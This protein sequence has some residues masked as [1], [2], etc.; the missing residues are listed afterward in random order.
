MKDKTQKNIRVCS[1]IAFVLCVLWTIFKMFYFVGLLTGKGGVAEKVNWSENNTIKIVYFILY[2]SS[3][4]MMIVLCFK[5]IINV[6]KGLREQIVFPQNNVKPLF[7]LALDSFVY[8]L[9][10]INQPLL[11][12]GGFAI[13]FVGTNFILPFLLLFF[14]FMYKVAADA[15]EENSLTI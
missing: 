14:A 10:W 4:V 15:V 9:C 7:W 2:L 12:Q 11:Y 13:S 3:T 8:M 1:I 6:L 5:V